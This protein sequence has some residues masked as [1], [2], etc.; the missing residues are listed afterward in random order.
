[1]HLFLTASD[2]ISRRSKDC[3]PGIYLGNY[4]KCDQ[5]GDRIYSRY[6]SYDRLSE[7]IELKGH[8]EDGIDN[9][10]EEV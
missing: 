1:M 8:M 9:A 3:L 10:F 6:E 2:L 7:F 4:H 5:P